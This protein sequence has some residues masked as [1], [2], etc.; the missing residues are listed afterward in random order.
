MQKTGTADF[1]W[2]DEL[3]WNVVEKHN[4]QPTASTSSALMQPSKQE[5]DQHVQPSTSCWS[6]LSFKEIGL[7]QRNISQN[8]GVSTLF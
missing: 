6:N 5:S 2:E 8:A 1:D 3:L 7:G 4:P